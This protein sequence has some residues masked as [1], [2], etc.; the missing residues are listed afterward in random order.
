MSK[1]PKSDE[2]QLDDQLS[3][4]TDQIMSGSG[5]ENM[6]EVFSGTELV[7]LQ[8]AVLQMKTAAQVARPTA[9]ANARVRS[10]LLSEWKQSQ[11]P[12]RPASRHFSWSLPRVVLAG[13]LAII[14]LVGLSLLF[15]SGSLTT[16]PLMGTAEG[17]PIGALFFIIIGAVL[18]AWLLWRDHRS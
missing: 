1:L 2:Q 10:R 13:G 7:E 6:D 11:L 8:K 17:S 12:K 15:T 3:E 9:E 18:V 16:T 14:S 4:F 5:Q